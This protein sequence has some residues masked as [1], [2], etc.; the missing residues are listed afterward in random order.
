MSYNY[1]FYAMRA[2]CNTKSFFQWVKVDRM[3][4]GRTP[5]SRKVRA[6]KRLKRTVPRH[7]P[8]AVT[9]PTRF[10]VRTKVI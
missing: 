1:T 3:V 9:L 6:W 7:R 2:S 5:H 10:W 4:L 8:S